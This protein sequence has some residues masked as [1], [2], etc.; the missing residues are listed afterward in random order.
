MSVRQ[1]FNIGEGSPEMGSWSLKLSPDAPAAWRD[2]AIRNGLFFDTLC[3]TATRLRDPG[4]TRATIL[5]KSIFSGYVERAAVGAMSEPWE[6]S[7]PSLVA[8]LGTSDNPTAGPIGFSSG[9]TV[10]LATFLTSLFGGGTPTGKYV[11]GLQLY[12]ASTCSTNNITDTAAGTETARQLIERWVRQTDDPTEWWVRPDGQAHFAKEGNSAIFT[13]APTVLFSRDIDSGTHGDLHAFRCSGDLTH[14]IAGWASSVVCNDGTNYE[15]A[16]NF[17]GV[18]TFSPSLKFHNSGYMNNDTADGGGM[19]AYYQVNGGSTAAAEAAYL[20][21][22][23][24]KNGFNV[25]AP[26]FQTS[27]EDRRERRLRTEAPGV[28]SFLKP[29]DYVW[30][31]DKDTGAYDRNNETVVGGRLLYPIKTRVA[32]MSWPITP[33]MGVYLISNSTGDPLDGSGPGSD[34]DTVTDLSDFVQYESGTTEVMLNTSGP[35]VRKETH[36]FQRAVETTAS[37][38]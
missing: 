8:W 5:S 31:Y 9:G 6:M 22:K 38:R 12:S 34:Y 29:G 13:Q 26:T 23:R 35:N 17:G 37:W 2:A 21:G 28:A 24:H 33:G 1:G 16:G 18:G 10:S 4:V 36:A 15:T 3:I 27:Y 20:W 14:S 19:A 7:G 11:N 25:G 32:A 30:Y